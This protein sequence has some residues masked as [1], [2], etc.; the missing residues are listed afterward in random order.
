VSKGGWVIDGKAANQATVNA[1][2]AAAA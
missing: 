2:E 1:K